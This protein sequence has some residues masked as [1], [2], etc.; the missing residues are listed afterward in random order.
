MNREQKAAAVAEIADQIRESDAVFAV[1]YRGITVT[2]TAELRGRLREADASFRIVKNTLTERAADEAGVE[3]LKPYLEGPTALTFVRGDVAVAAKAIADLQKEWELLEFKGGLMGEE[4]LDADADQGDRQA[5]VAPGALRPARRHHRLADHRPGAE[6]QRAHVRAWRS[7]S[8]A[9]W[10]RR[11]RARSR[12]AQIPRPPRLGRGGCRRGRGVRQPTRLRPRRRLS[13]EAPAEETADGGT[14]G[15]RGGAS[16]TE[17]T[18]QADAS[19]AAD[20]TTT[21][22]NEEQ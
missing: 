10:R 13:T 9:C 16:N 14:R 18:E 2:Q 17:E 3:A 22:A 19:A 1:D 4:S 15:R 20:E 8:A 5:A 11:S 21:E 6:P 12:P 7:R